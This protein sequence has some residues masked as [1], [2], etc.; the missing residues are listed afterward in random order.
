MFYLFT[1]FRRGMACPNLAK[2]LGCQHCR[3]TTHLKSNNTQESDWRCFMTLLH[4]LREETTHTLNWST[5]SAVRGAGRDATADRHTQ[6]NT[7]VWLNET[8]MD[9]ITT[10]CF[11]NSREIHPIKKCV[12]RDF[13]YIIIMQQ[14]NVLLISLDF[15]FF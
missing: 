1:A 10:E 11:I 6:S 7:W 12:L 4:I 13:I 3:H 14:P 2:P 15:G 5:V 9:N 8:Q